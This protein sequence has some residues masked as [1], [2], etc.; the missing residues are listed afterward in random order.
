[1][2]IDYRTYRSDAVVWTVLGIAGRLLVAV[3]FS[4]R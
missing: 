3:L 1:M 4:R 2:H